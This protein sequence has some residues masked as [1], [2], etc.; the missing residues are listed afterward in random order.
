MLLLLLLLLMVM[1]MVTTMI[2]TSSSHSSQ[3]LLKAAVATTRSTFLHATFQASTL[4]LTCG[5]SSGTPSSASA[6]HHRTQPL[7]RHH[8]TQLCIKA[9]WG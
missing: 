3:T 8:R 4:W 1:M 6:R 9:Y 2:Q 7:T 5:P